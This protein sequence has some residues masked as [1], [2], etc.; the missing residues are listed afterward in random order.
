MTVL[1]GHLEIGFKLPLHVREE[2]LSSCPD[3]CRL[4]YISDIHLHRGRSKRL[5]M[6]V[7][8]A[9]R[10][11]GANV[12]LLGG[13]LV[14]HAS[15][16]ESLRSLV[17]QLIRFGPV[18]AVGGNHDSHVGAGRVR[19]AVVK[20]GGAWIH[21]D[22]VDIPHI[23]R[24]ISVCGPDFAAQTTGDVRVLLA[25]NPRIWKTARRGGY[26][27]VLAG[28]LHGCQFVAFEFRD[29]L[30]PGAVF[31]PYNYLSHQ[32]G[33]TRLV[34]SRGVSDLVPIRWRCPRE[35]VLCYV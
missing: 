20:G 28:H 17:E 9:V 26:N 34:V 18:L 8:E 11:A 32:F 27:L 29:R 1:A 19:E 12:V 10:R 6:Q 4:L 35:V 15:E 13:D 7:V 33:E 5:A 23:S 2:R 14:D 21:E 25:H 24:V 31:Y 30:F 3:A 22:S 16:L